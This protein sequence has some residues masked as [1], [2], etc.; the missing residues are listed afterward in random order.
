MNT[1]TGSLKEENRSEVD[2]FYNENIASMLSDATNKEQEDEFVTVQVEGNSKLEA[3]ENISELYNT[4][5]SSPL[6]DEETDLGGTNT[7]THSIS[8]RSTEATQVTCNRIEGMERHVEV[9]HSSTRRSVDTMIQKHDPY[10]NA[11]TKRDAQPNYDRLHHLAEPVV[12]A[13]RMANYKRDERRAKLLGLPPPQPLTTTNNNNSNNNDAGTR[14]HNFV[15]DVPRVVH[16]FKV[17]RPFCTKTQL[18]LLFII[19][20]FFS[21]SV[22][23]LVVIA[24]ETISKSRSS[25]TL[26]ETRKNNI[27]NNNNN[28]HPGSGNIGS[29]ISTV[30]LENNITG[31]WFT[32]SSDSVQFTMNSTVPTSQQLDPFAP[33][34]TT[35]T[36]TSLPM[37]DLLRVTTPVPSSRSCSGVYPQPPPFPGK[38]GVAMLLQPL[39]TEDSWIENLPKLLQLAPYWNHAYS[40]QRLDAQPSSIEFVPMVWDTYPDDDL[41]S[42]LT[43][44][45]APYIDNGKVKHLLTF[46]EPDEVMQANTTVLQALNV[47]HHLESVNLPLVSPSCAQPHGTWIDSFMNSA[48]RECKRVDWMGV[49]WFGEP[50][51]VDFKMSMESLY[52]KYQRPLVLTEFAP[53]DWNA[54]SVKEH[55]F[56]VSTVLDFM[57]KSV[58]WLENT[59]YIAGYAWAPFKETDP[60]GTSAALFNSWGQLT[61]LGRFY[62]SVKVNNTLGDQSIVE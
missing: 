11:N 31:V 6:E 35:T 1:T 54:T 7:T 21:I 15:Q 13:R 60:I 28:N 26:L 23:L 19:V 56:T 57:K 14:F 61:S 32:D 45:V 58:P 44:H 47:W 17:Q 39:N 52:Q 18:I 43:E 27:N 24:K 4:H 2:L 38:K 40:L 46:H 51:F 37:D 8:S 22:A 34:T 12:A 49:H 29:N 25:N 16:G 50:N 53:A 36:P 9:N 3:H 55:S 59:N 20:L 42:Q 33:T 41:V 10:K 62:A 30:P 5:L 48:L